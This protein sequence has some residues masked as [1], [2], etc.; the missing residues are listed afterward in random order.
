MK[1]YFSLLIFAACFSGTLPAQKPGK[2]Q[3]SGNKPNKFSSGATNGQ[4]R[5]VNNTKL[6]DL[7]NPFDTT[8]NV[9]T[10]QADSFSWGASNPTSQNQR[11]QQPVVRDQKWRDD[12]LLWIKNGKKPESDNFSWGASNPTSQNQRTQQP[13]ISNQKWRDD[14]LLWIKN[15]GK[16]QTGNYSFGANQTGGFQQA[17]NSQGSNKHQHVVVA[18]NGNDPDSLR[19]TNQAAKANANANQTNTNNQSQDK[20][21]HKP[22]S[23][24]NRASENIQADRYANQETNYIKPA[25]QVTGSQR[26]RKN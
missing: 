19:Q 17:Q 12:S 15:G 4:S 23:N 5:Q 25:K 16:P 2:L 14:S 10:E 18:Y 3:S 11:T 7:K 13:A 24:Q 26:K 21:Q 8:K 22:I 20:R 6:D 9:K 1:R